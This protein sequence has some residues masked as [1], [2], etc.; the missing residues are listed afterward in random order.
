MKKTFHLFLIGKQ[1]KLVNEKPI[2]AQGED[3]DAIAPVI[4]KQMETYSLGSIQCV[5]VY[6]YGGGFVG[7]FTIADYLNKNIPKK[8]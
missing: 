6:E 2:V 1:S 5:M 8:S 4:I 3:L 7:Q